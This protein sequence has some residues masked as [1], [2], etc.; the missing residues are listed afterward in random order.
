MAD[1]YETP[2]TATKSGDI[3]ASC[4]A[5]ET[6]A[7]QIRTVMASRVIVQVLSRLADTARGREPVRRLAALRPTGVRLVSGAGNNSPP[8]FDLR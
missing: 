6:V 5:Q 8:R 3:A 4:P 7:G 2:T 1:G